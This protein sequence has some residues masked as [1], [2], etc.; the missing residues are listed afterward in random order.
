[1]L[2]CNVFISEFRVSVFISHGINVFVRLFLCVFITVHRFA[3]WVC[4]CVGVYMYECVLLFACCHACMCAFVC[5]CV[6]VCV[7]VGVRACVCVFNKM[8]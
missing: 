5:L 8:P 3:L 6:C 1:M 4:L 7:C 2:N